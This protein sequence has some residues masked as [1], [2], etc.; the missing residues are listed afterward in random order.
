[1]HSMHLHLTQRI[2]VEDIVFGGHRALTE[3]FSAFGYERQGP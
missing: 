2:G 1:M 3:S